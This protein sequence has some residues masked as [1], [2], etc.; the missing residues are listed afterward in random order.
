MT[1][2]LIRNVYLTA[3]MILLRLFIRQKPVQR[4]DPA[5]VD[6][7]L[8]IRIDRIGDMVVSVP[9]I[10][11]LKQL[12]PSSRMTAL[13]GCSTV[14]LARLVPEID[15]VIVY[16]GFLPALISLRKRRFAVVVDLLM[17]YTLKT[18]SLAFLS[19]GRITCGFDIAARGR[20]FNAA[21]KP[22]S[23]L[24]QMSRYL[25]DLVCFLSALSGKECV[26]ADIDP[27]LTLTD[28]ARISSREF[29]Q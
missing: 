24:K 3:R 25:L 12:F 15:E 11:A 20:F 27:V 9:A 1:K 7:I 8:V 19:G 6:S 16:R 13:L 26:R 14:D 10:K 29:L 17:D 23:G 5:G 4:I 21:F 18:A 22:L 28:S 2:A